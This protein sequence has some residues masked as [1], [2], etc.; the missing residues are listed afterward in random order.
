MDPRAALQELYL[1]D[2]LPTPVIHATNADIGSILSEGLIPGGPKAAVTWSTLPPNF[3]TRRP[4]GFSG[5]NRQDQRVTRPLLWP[6]GTQKH[7]LGYAKIAGT[8]VR[9]YKWLQSGRSTFMN[10]NQVVLINE[11]IHPTFFLPHRR[12]TAR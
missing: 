2:T 10:V 3:R 12:C 5:K 8:T 6:G 9:L 7:C 1:N 11:T 4:H